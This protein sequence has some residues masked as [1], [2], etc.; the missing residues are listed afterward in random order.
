MVQLIKM[1][2]TFFQYADVSNKYFTEQFES[3]WECVIQ[4][5]GSLTNH[6]GLIGDRTNDVAEL[7]GRDAPNIQDVT[8]ST[9]QIES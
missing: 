7:A 1:C 9:G 3:L 6:P 8:D 4:Q 5:G 2:C